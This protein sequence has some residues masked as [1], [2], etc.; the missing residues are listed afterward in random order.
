[1]IATIAYF[2]KPRFLKMAVFLA[3]FL[4]VLSCPV[5][6]ALAQANQGVR[7]PGRPAAR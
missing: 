6:L 4:I 5:L 7:C 1:V 3:G 2:A